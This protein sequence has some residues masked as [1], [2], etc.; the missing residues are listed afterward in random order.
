MDDRSG[1]VGLGMIAQDHKGHV[2]AMQSSTT[3]HISNPTTTET[4]VAWNTVVLGVQLSVIHLELEGDAMEVVQEINRAS[5][6]YGRE[7]PILNNMKTLLQ[8]FNT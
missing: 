2:L 4:L 5:H 3:K 6:C 7:G 1:T 8:N